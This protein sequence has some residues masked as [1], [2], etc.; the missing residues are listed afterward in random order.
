MYKD[1]RAAQREMEELRRQVEREQAAQQS[2][3]PIPTFEQMM[4]EK[5]AKEANEARQYMVG[6]FVTAVVAGFLTVLLSR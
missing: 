1:G 5:R 2:R 6:M 3:Y 4:R